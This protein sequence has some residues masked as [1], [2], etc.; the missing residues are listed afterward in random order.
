MNF[1]EYCRNG[2]SLYEEFAQQVK[3]LLAHALETSE[4]NSNFWQITYRPKSRPSLRNK[5]RDRQVTADQDIEAEIKDLAGCRLIFYRNDQ[6]NAFLQSDILNEYFNIDWKETKIHQPL[7]DNATAEELYRA[8]HYIVTLKD[9]RTK[10]PEFKKFAG[11]RCEIQI[12]T[13]LNHAWSETGHDLIYKPILSEGFGAK[14]HEEIKNR[15]A[16]VMKD[17]LI[18]AGYEFQK[19]Y[20]DYLR[21]KEGKILFDRNI[22]N[23]IVVAKDNN[24]RYEILERVLNHVIP[25]YDDIAGVYDELVHLA[26]TAIEIS[27][28]TE[29]VPI[30]TPFSD[31]PGIEKSQVSAKA[32]EIL[33]Y[34]RYI[35]SEKMFS[36]LIDLYLTGS[37]DVK[38]Q[39]IKAGIKLAKHNRQ[40]WENYGPAIPHILIETL[41]KIPNEQTILL[42]PLVI[43]VSKEILNTEI[44][45]TTSTYK[46]VTFSSGTVGITEDLQSVRTKIISVLTTAYSNIDI[47]DERLRVIDGLSS[48]MCTPV[49]GSNDEMHLM[50]LENTLQI[51]EFYKSQIGTENFEILQ[52]LETEAFWIKKRT[53]GL[54]LSEHSSQPLKE[55]AKYVFNWL[56][57]Y[58]AEINKIPEY[59]RFKII[60]GYR[61][62]SDEDWK[63][64]NYDYQFRN[65]SRLQKIDA[66]IESINQTEVNEWV[67][68]IKYCGRVDSR[69]GAT[70][71]H[72]YEFLTKLFEKKPEFFTEF[73]ANI[74]E[75]LV[76]F[77]PPIFA[78]L[79][80]S[81]L[82]ADARAYIA[83]W[84]AKRLNLQQISHFYLIIGMCD[85]KSLRSL[86]TAALEVKND[87]ALWNLSNTC[88][89]A[90]DSEVNEDLIQ[91]FLE[92]ID[93]FNDINNSDWVN[94]A[95]YRVNES[96]L[97]HSLNQNQLSKVLQNLVLNPK[98]DTHT[99][100]ILKEIADKYPED[101][102]RFFKQRIDYKLT[103][104][105][106]N[107]GWLDRYEDVP[108]AFESLAEKF[109]NVSQAVIDI[110]IE[111]YPPDIEATPY[112]S[113][114]SDTSGKLIANLYPA[115]EGLETPLIELIRAKH[116]NSIDFVIAILKNY[117]GET[118]VHGVAKELLIF[119][120]ANDS[121]RFRHI[122]FA[123]DNMGVVSGEYGTSNS[124][125]NKKSEITTWLTDDREQVRSFAAN[126]IQN[127][128][129]QIASERRREEQRHELGKLQ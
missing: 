108:F 96:Y 50:V 14:Q 107:S 87:L 1:T 102:I 25:N 54:M 19:V 88:L 127:L 69:D 57:T 59:V 121:D 82:Q 55:K 16:K 97:F 45:S 61:Y 42:L 20:S 103:L 26:L 80:K 30:S 122:E 9:E 110:V 38:E 78:G 52:Q 92:T 62:V 10:L 4:D 98:V 6:V 63:T 22:L 2:Y 76:K 125:K 53:N 49:R 13:I 94:H 29:T 23:D 18:P 7:D 129:K 48:A 101:V 116:P 115:F 81:K 44:Q 46:E 32:F 77:I 123:L 60:I 84:E 66:Y 119:I 56:D 33:S 89:I 27:S 36:V 112:S 104:P 5:L 17:Y 40:I 124:Y 86:F 99:E 117:K 21:L 65:E 79:W 31:Y 113:W 83:E 43:A 28:N 71:S 39:A 51:F 100:W 24:Q 41:S 8:Q 37:A 64:L 47:K 74:P 120:D 105:T 34:A 12:Q 70:L 91:L 35:N 93:Y 72:F 15:M 73:I 109:V 85:I 95:W 3:N 68:F 67:E 11:L 90:K 114:F 111:W 126:Y 128:D 118:F 106:I 58:Y 75:G